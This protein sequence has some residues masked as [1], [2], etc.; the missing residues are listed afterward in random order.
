MWR[1]Q[2]KKDYKNNQKSNCIF[3]EEIQSLI[4]P[5]YAQKWRKMQIQGEIK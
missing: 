5:H 3:L 1:K 4:V 2:I